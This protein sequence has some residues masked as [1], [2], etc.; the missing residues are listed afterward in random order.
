MVTA[1]TVHLRSASGNLK[2]P[3]GTFGFSVRN[4]QATQSIILDFLVYLTIKEQP[5]APYSGMMV[6]MV[7]STGCLCHLWVHIRR[8][9]RFQ[10]VYIA[11]IVKDYYDRIYAPNIPKPQYESWLPALGDPETDRRYIFILMFE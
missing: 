11:P 5:E 1:D 9:S 4:L 6:H 8:L 10:V 3:G 2:M 7:L